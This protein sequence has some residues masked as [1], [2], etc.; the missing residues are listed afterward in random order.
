MRAVLGTE[1]QSIEQRV[2]MYKYHTSQIDPSD[3]LYTEVNN[4][5][6]KMAVGRRRYC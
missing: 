2:S 4:Q 3:V 5:C 1:F 6:V